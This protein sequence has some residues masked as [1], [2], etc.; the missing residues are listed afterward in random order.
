MY[1]YLELR[2]KLLPLEYVAIEGW[3]IEFSQLRSRNW[4]GSTCR[5]RL[6]WGYF[7]VSHFPYGQ[8]EVPE[9]FASFCYGRVPELKELLIRAVTLNLRL[10]GLVLFL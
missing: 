10:E 6:A 9:L 8:S 5:H 2:P 7:D 4:R 1:C 3:S